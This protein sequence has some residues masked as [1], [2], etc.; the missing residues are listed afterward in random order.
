MAFLVWLW[1]YL[2]IAPHVLLA[3]LFVFML[4]RRLYREFP[5]FC[6]YAGFQAIQFIVLFSLARTPSTSVELYFLAHS[7]SVALSTALRF[8]VLYEVFSH[9]LRDYAV[10]TSLKGA[11]LRWG[12]M[13]LLLVSLVLA[14]Y[15]KGDSRDRDWFLLQVM[16]RTVL[17]LQS[18]LL[19]GLFLFSRYLNLSWRTP[20]F[21]IA[22]GVGTFATV[23]LAVA[24]IKSQTGFSYTGYLDYFTMGS[25]HVS[26]LIWM[27]YLLAPDRNVGI[28]RAPAE[29][30]E[31][32]DV[33]AWNQ[34]LERLLR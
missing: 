7:T 18:G 23:G 21:G 34:E 33:E 25:Y 5:V 32:T 8:G 14:L 10:L 13:G 9:L 6:A 19:L 31:H 28:G 1:Y 26:V 17:F 22:L 27:V 30:P 4:Y 2:W 3:G 11:L 16:N 15:T 12:T 24:A 20:T 29:L